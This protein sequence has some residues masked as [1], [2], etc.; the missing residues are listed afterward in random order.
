MACHQHLPERLN[1]NPLVQLY[2]HPVPIVTEACDVAEGSRELGVCVVEIVS[3]KGINLL[4][5]PFTTICIMYTGGIKL[6]RAEQSQGSCLGCKAI[7]RGLGDAGEFA[8]VDLPEQHRYQQDV[9]CKRENA[10]Y[11]A[12]A[13]FVTAE[14]I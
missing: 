8:A 6:S 14:V 4:T 13:A 2:P 10:V 11:T 7:C 3:Q 12:P 5:E 9:H 1:P